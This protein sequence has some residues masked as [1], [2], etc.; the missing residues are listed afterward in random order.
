MYFRS[1]NRA[2]GYVTPMVQDKRVKWGENV[3][4]SELD[5]AERKRYH[6]AIRQRQRRQNKL[7]NPEEKET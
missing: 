3:D 6:A 7:N 1:F 4:V 5:S 2:L